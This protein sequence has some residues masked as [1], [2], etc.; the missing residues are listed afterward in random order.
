MVRSLGIAILAVGL[1]TPALAQQSDAPAA[2][3]QQ[4]EAFMNQWVA[5]YNRGDGQAMAALTTTDAFGVGDQG[6]ISGNQRFEHAVQNEAALGAKVTSMEVQQVRMLGRNAAV[7]AGPYSVSYSNPQPLTVKGTWMQVLERQRGN[8][9]S[10]A[11]SYTPATSPPVP[12]AAGAG[13][14]PPAEGSSTH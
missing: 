13:N 4:I 12:T 5:A 6:V 11:A 8:W 7:A 9:R 3:R 10:V 2:A 14:P 1:A